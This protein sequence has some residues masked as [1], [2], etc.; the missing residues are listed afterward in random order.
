MDTYSPEELPHNHG[1]DNPP[2]PPECVLQW[3]FGRFTGMAIRVLGT[4][5]YFTWCPIANEQFVVP[6]DAEDTNPVFIFHDGSLHQLSSSKFYYRSSASP[7]P[8]VK[9]WR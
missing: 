5:G 6:K 1:R 3:N 9:G 2:P 7:L 4:D 8:V